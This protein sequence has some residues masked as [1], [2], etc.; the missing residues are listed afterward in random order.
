MI[1]GDFRKQSEIVTT[2]LVGIWLDNPSVSVP[3]NEELIFHKYCNSNSKNE[4]G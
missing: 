4:I 3:H 1:L 2:D